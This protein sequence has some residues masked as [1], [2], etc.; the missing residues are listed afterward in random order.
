MGDEEAVIREIEPGRGLQLC[1]QAAHTTPLC[2]SCR[3]FGHVQRALCPRV[4]TLPPARSGLYLGSLRSLGYLETH[5]ITHVLVRVACLAAAG[6]QHARART[7]ARIVE[8][9][10]PL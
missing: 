7:R 9:A 1:Q 6:C 10:H 5:G 3:A 4:A 8:H 2:S